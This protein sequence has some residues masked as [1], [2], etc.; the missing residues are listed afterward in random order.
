MEISVLSVLIVCLAFAIV[1]L[2]DLKGMEHE[3]EQDM[4][5]QDMIFKAINDCMAQLEKDQKE[6]DNNTYKH[7]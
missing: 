1:M 3:M 5:R 4:T 2:A 6:F 7:D